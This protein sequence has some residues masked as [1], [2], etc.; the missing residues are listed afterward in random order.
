MATATK[1][2]K[3]NNRANVQKTLADLNTT[4]VRT[5]EDFIEGTVKTGEQYQKLIAKTLKNGQPVVAKQVDLVFDTLEGIK[6]Q[7]QYGSERFR[8][9][10]GWNDKTIENW[11]KDAK[12][13]V[14]NLRKNVEDKIEDIQEDLN[15]F[16]KEAEKATKTVAKKAVK[17]V[18]AKP[19][20]K[21]ATATKKVVKKVT[22]KAVAVKKQINLKLIDGVGPAMEKILKGAGI[23]SIETLATSTKTKLT[24]IIETAGPRYRM[25]DPTTW[26]KQAKEL[27]K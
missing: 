20:A 24:K 1:S 11:R 21:K 23:D 18:A 6:D 15:I 25:I 26:V 12:K 17:K 10:V 19:V 22:K 13:S 2:K 8:K 14:K 3:K 27:T 7:F 5:S 4:L 9:L 16:G